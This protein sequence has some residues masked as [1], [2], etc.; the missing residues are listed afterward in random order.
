[1]TFG[2]FLPLSHP[3]SSVS[4][5]TNF[6]RVDSTWDWQSA[7]DSRT[8][9]C[10]WKVGEKGERK[11]LSRRIRSWEHLLHPGYCGDT[12]GS[13]TKKG[14]A[15]M[16]GPHIKLL[17]EGACPA[18]R[19]FLAGGRMSLSASCGKHSHRALLCSSQDSALRGK[20]KEIR[21]NPSPPFEQGI[22]TC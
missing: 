12:Q 6:P 15:G 19:T 7:A 4:P 18:C 22:M 16:G 10:C 20:H 1:M 11:G 17:G 5:H 8:F 3:F 13:K 21:T 9:S 14:A 2:L